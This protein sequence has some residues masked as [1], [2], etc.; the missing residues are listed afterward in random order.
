MKKIVPI[1]PSYNPTDIL[2]NYIETLYQNNFK[3][4]IVI[5]DGSKNKDIF[6]KLKKFKYCIVLTHKINL[7]K[8]AALKTGF[9]YYARN[10]YNKFDG[11]ITIDDDNQHKI[12]DVLKLVKF[13]NLDSLVLGVRNFN[14]KNVPF[15]SRIGNKITSFMFKLLYKKKISDTQTGLRIYPN[16]L[17]K[18]LCYLEGNNFDFET[19]ILIYCIKKNI[20]ITEITINTIYIN[21]NKSSRFKPIKDSFKI[22]KILFKGRKK[23]K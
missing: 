23:Y 5:D 3:T 7:G 4:I 16:F 22:Y 11:A 19:N 10:L 18:Q 9:R 20:N 21:K 1:I 2:I 15:K 6:E 17:I 13:E 8:G 14:S 12:E